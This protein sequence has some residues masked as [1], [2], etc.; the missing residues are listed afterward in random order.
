M[1]LAVEAIEHGI[2]AAS[3]IPGASQGVE[4]KLSFRISRDRTGQLLLWDAV[5][6]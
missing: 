4:L 2:P 1:H 5:M 6:L 3:H